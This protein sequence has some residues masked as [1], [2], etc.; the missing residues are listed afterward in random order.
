MPGLRQK[1]HSQP[2]ASQ[3]RAS[4]SGIMAVIDDNK[5]QR[6]TESSRF[7]GKLSASERFGFVL[8]D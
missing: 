3:D 8:L 6:L 5:H 1:S 7:E 2:S 4:K